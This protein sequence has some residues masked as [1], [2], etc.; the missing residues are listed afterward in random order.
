MSCEPRTGSTGSTGAGRD[1]FWASAPQGPSDAAPHQDAAAPTDT[2]CA[3]RSA[4]HVAVLP[5]VQLVIEDVEWEVLDARQRAELAQATSILAAALDR[6]GLSQSEQS[7]AG[8]PHR[9]DVVNLSHS[10]E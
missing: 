7:Q 2:T 8:Q 1:R 4:V 5:N 3:G 9:N 6:L 10:E